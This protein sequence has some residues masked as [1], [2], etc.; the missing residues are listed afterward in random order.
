MVGRHYFYGYLHAL[1]LFNRIVLMDNSLNNRTQL[2]ICINLSLKLAADENFSAIDFRK[3]KYHMMIKQLD[4]YIK[5]EENIIRMLNGDTYPQVGGL[6]DKVVEKIGKTQ[7]KI[8]V[9]RKILTNIFAGS[10][11]FDEYVNVDGV[12]EYEHTNIIFFALLKGF[13]EV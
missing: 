1:E 3:I 7:N 6:V 10:A 2:L 8:S 13:P 4:E 9:A 12:Q 11:T 5:A